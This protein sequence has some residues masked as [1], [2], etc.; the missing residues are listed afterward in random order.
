MVKLIYYIVGGDDVESNH[1]NENRPDKG[2]PNK[3]IIGGAAILILAFIPTVYGLSLIHISS[4][5]C[6]HA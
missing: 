1:N 4:Y 2:S 6:N 3:A 5:Q